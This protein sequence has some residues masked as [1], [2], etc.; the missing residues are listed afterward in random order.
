M[1]YSIW[2]ITYSKKILC[3]INRWYSIVWS[4]MRLDYHVCVLIRVTLN[5]HICVHLCVFWYIL[6]Y[7]YSH[8]CTV[9]THM[10][11]QWI[12]I[13]VYIYVCYDVYPYMWP[14]I[15]LQRELIYVYP[16]MCLDEHSYMCTHIRVSDNT[17]MSARIW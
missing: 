5:I 15:W 9:L 4:N 13:Y 17:Y 1:Y 2:I 10:W 7:V 16:Y 3:W 11:F 8:M 12:L 14:H 6:T